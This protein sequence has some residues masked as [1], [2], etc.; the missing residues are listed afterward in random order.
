MKSARYALALAGGYA[1]LAAIYIVVSSRIAANLSASVDELRRI[2]T[3][4][5]V[6]FVV[7]TALAVFAGSWAMFS[8]LERAHAENRSRAAA[9]LASERRVFA[10]LLA[11][12]TAH[13]ANNVLMTV[14]ADLEELRAVLGADPKVERLTEA[15]ERLIA[16]NCRLG[17]TVRHGRAG[18]V[19]DVPLL[20]EIRHALDSIHS[21][22]LV[23]G[24]DVRVHGDEAF[25]VRTHPLLVHQIITNLV[26]NAAEATQRHGRIDVW[27]KRTNDAALLE[28]HDDGPGVPEARRPGLFDAL[29]SSKADGGGLGLFSVK[30]CATAL[31]G[32]VEV[33]ASPLGGACFR[34]RL[35]VNSLDESAQR[36]PVPATV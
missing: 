30:A 5:G 31:G 6:L 28:V 8:R 15:T 14:I 7:V 22:L 26:L 2:E 18:E 36:Q 17:D 33:G 11:A 12:S 34:V 1:L 24:C 16:L 23:R 20:N 29:L 21:H 9:I 32:S 10:G 19:R 3:T 25:V 13:D 35:P 27:V 4:K